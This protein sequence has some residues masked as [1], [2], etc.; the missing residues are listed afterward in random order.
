MKVIRVKVERTVLQDADVLVRVPDFLTQHDPM[1]EDYLTNMVYDIAAMDG[2]WE[3]VET[4]DH[5]WSVI[6]DPFIEGQP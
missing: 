5:N 4:T 6:A 2:A 3:L 1:Y